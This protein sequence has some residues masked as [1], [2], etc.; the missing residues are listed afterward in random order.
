MLRE[1]DA[2]IPPLIATRTYRAPS[3]LLADAERASVEIA[4]TDADARS[5]SQA[6]GRFL[7]RTESVASS[8]IERVSA[9][10]DDFAK[11][12]A[13]SRANASAASMVAASVA[14]HRLVRR[15]SESG[16]L[17]L[18]DL[19]EA[20]HDL[21]ADDPAEAPYAGRLRDIQ[22]W[23]GG[24]SHAPRGALYVPPP[25][26]FVPSLMD[27]LLAWMNRDDIPVMIQ[28]AV[29]HAQFESIHP[30]TDGNGR[31]G[32]ALISAILRRRGV[33]RNVVMPLA[34]GILAIRDEYF[35]AL[36]SYRAGDPRPIIG[37]V[38]RS[39][40]VAA[41]ESRVS[42]DE[43]RALPDRWRSE[44]TGRKSPVIDALVDA[45][46][47][48]PVMRGDEIVTAAGSSATAAYAAIERLTDAGILTE[49]TGRKRDRVWT[50]PDALG[51]LEDLDRRI[52]AAM[53]DAP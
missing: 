41:V 21:M 36:T 3:A 1:V 45:F 37:V 12:L 25:A 6:L 24:S 18:Q 28:A 7:L 29:A 10:V 34:S 20:H 27:D 47:D 2:S 33:A 11:A 39:S 19:L 48:N 49:V 22:N 52:Q 23:I 40:H 44:L 31:I 30:F 38:T 15:A 43:L 26:D 9:S 4:A 32:R 17:V 8:K 53:L 46:F 16:V 14:L 42:I 51:E 13:G 50:A 5:R 35:A